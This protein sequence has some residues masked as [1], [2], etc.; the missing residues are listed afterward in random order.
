MQP[1]RTDSVASAPAG[2][3]SPPDAFPLTDMQEAYCVGRFW[4]AGSAARVYVEF[5]V[6]DVDPTA[7]EDAWNAVVAETGMLRAVILPDGRQAVRPRVPRHRLPV[8]DLR[9][10]GPDDRDA[11]LE[12]LRER[13]HGTPLDPYDGPLFVMAVALLPGGRARVH[14]ALD[15]LVV[16]GP[17]VS[18]LLHRWYALYRGGPVPPPPALGFRDYVEAVRARENP[19]R[20]EAALAYWRDKLS[21][22]RMR[23]APRAG[24]GHPG[25]AGTRGVR[26]PAAAGAARRRLTLRLP[27]DR[28]RRVTGHAAALRVT[29]SALLLTLYGSLLHR[30]LPPDGAGPLPLVITTYNRLPVHPDVPRVV[31]PFVSTSV[32]LAP[33][34]TASLAVLSG[35]VR[36][37][38]WA[39]LEHGAVSGVRALRER[40]ARDGD[41]PGAP[42]YVFTSM[43][44]TLGNGLG[45]AGTAHGAGDDVWASAAR[46]EAGRTRTP[47][48]WLECIVH[49]RAGELHVVLDHD[50]E[51]IG[52]DLA[53]RLLSAWSTALGTLA[54]LA[55]DEAAGLPDPAA[56]FEPRPA[57]EAGA[58]EEP[59]DARTRLPLT[60]MQTAYLVGRLTTPGVAGETRVHQEFRLTSPDLRRLGDAWRL[61]VRRHPALRARIGEDGTLSVD[62]AP[63]DPAAPR[64]PHHD[65]THL[66][67]AGAE[68]A[69]TERRGRLAATSLPLDEGPLWRLET[70]ALP[71]G[72]VVLHVLF[73]AL[74]ADARA[75]AT[76]F[77]QLFRLHAGEPPE[78]VLPA[79]PP[80]F[81]PF[82]RARERARQGPA[83][84][85]ARAV[86]DEVL[87]RVPDG[88]GPARRAVAPATAGSEHRRLDVPGWR[89]LRARADEWG[90]APDIVL[91]TVYCD[92]WRR[93]CA[94]GEPFTVVVVSWD[95][96][97]NPPGAGELVTDFTRL[98]WLVVDDSLPAEFGAR[99]RAVDARLRVDLER[100]AVADGLAAARAR[101]RPGAVPP[102]PV[103]FT[104][105]PA[106]QPDGIPGVELRHSQSRTSGVA[107]DHVPMFVGDTLVCQWD[108]RA[109]VLPDGLLDALFADY[110]AVVRDLAG[111]ETRPVPDPAG[112]DTRP[113][114]G[115]AGAP[116]G[117]AVQAALR[118]PARDFRPELTLADRLERA[119]AAHA[120]RLAV[121]FEDEE[122]T[123]REL[124]ARSARLARFLRASGA[125]PGTRVAVRMDRSAALVTALLAVVRAG[126]AYV[127]LDPAHPPARTRLLAEDCEPV[128]VLTDER[129][130]TGLEGST[131]PVVAVDPSGA[132][133][134]HLDDGP[135]ESGATPADPAYMIYTSGTTGRPKGCPN[136]H[137]AVSNRLN[138]AQETF[139]LRPGDRVAQKTPY[140][141]DVSVWEFFWPL[142]AGAAVVVAR[143]EGHR[144][145]AYLARW[146][147]ESGVTVAHFVPSMLALFLAEPEAARA[148]S[149]RLVL[150]S[151][152]ALPAATA[153]AFGRVLPGAE[154]HNL[155]GPTEAAIDVTHWAVPPGWS[156]TDVPLG[157][158]IDNT[159][160]RLLD[161]RLSPVAAGEPGEICV[162]GPAV[163]LGYHRRPEE[164]ALR[165]VPSPFAEDGGG[166]LYRTGDLG[167]VGPD[168]LL[169]YLGRQDDQFKI[170]GLRVEA[171]EVEAALLAVPGIAQARVLPWRGP[172]DEPQLA[173]VCVAGDGGPVPVARLR[174]E[175]ART[176]PAPLLPSRTVFTDALP[177]TPNGKLD[178][179][180]A[181]RLLDAPGRTAAAPAPRDRPGPAAACAPD[182]EAVAQLAAS[183]LDGTAV[184]PDDDLFALG[185]TSFTMIRLA[186]EIERRHGTRVPVDLLVTRPTARGVAEGL[187]AAPAGAGAADG[188]G[189][190]GGPAGPRDAADVR[191]AF[192]PEAK[193]A[194]K[195]ERRSLRRF[196]EDRPRVALDLPADDGPAG[197]CG[198]SVR[199]FDPAPLSFR[200]LS[201]LARSFTQPGPGHGTRRPYPSAGG[202][203]P[204]QVY[205][206]VKP[207]RVTG[208]GPGVY[209]LDPAERALVP[210]TEGA[211][212]DERSQ[213]RYNRPLFTGAAFGLFLV[214]TPRAIEPAYGRA[215]GTRYTA[216]E[217]GHMCQ[218]AMERAS[219][220]GLGLCPIG[221]MD[222]TAVREHF[223]L[224]DGQD[225]VV[226]LWGG[227]LPDSP[228]AP[229]PATATPATSTA[230]LPASGISPPAL[231]ASGVSPSPPPASDVSPTGTA[232]SPCSA[233]SA[234]GEVPPGAV[235]VIG[236]AGLL[237]GADPA[238]SVAGLGRLLAEGGTAIGPPPPG[239]AP[240]PAPR[241]ARGGATVGAYLPDVSAWEPDEWGIPPQEAAAVDPQEHLLLAVVRGCLENAGTR[242]ETLSAAGP[243]GVFTG[244][245]WHDHGRRGGGT[246]PRAVP[247]MTGL[248]HRVSHAFDFHGTSL[249]VDAGCASGLA[250][251]DAALRALRGGQCTTAVAAAVNL[252]L[253]G[254]HLEFLAETGLLAAS[255]GSRPLSGRSDGWI[256]GEGVGAVLLKPLE[257]ALADGDPVHAV[258][259]GGSC[260]H[261]GTTRGYGMPSPRRQE[262]TMRAALDDAGVTADDIGYV[263]SSATGAAVADALELEV[264]GRVLGDRPQ[265]VPVGSVKGVLGHMEAASAF[266][267]L[268]KVLAQFRQDRLLP[269]PLPPDASSPGG[270]GRV[271]VVG[272]VEPWPAR[273][274]V[275]LNSFAGT[276]GYASVVLEAP[277]VR[278]C[279]PVPAG[280]VTLPLSAGSPAALAAYAGRLADHLEREAP[281]L[282]TVAAALRGG[283]RDRRCRAAV[284]VTGDGAVPA[285]R[286]LAERVS[287]QGGG[288]V[289]TGAGVPEDREPDLPSGWL[290]GAD[291]PWP[292]APG[293]VPRAALPPT[294]VDT[295]PVAPR[296][297][298]APAPPDAAS[299]PTPTVPGPAPEP[300]LPADAQDTAAQDAG[301]RETGARDA[302]AQD[303]PA[304]STTAGDL[305]PR[306]V[307]P[308]EPAP[309][310]PLLRLAGIVAR[311]TGLPAARLTEGT[312]LLTLGVDSLRL[313]RIVH[314]ISAAGGRAPS[315]T[316]LYE[317]PV[318]GALA[319]AAFPPAAPRS[320]PQD[321][322]A[323][324]EDEIDA[325]DESVLDA[326]LARHTAALR[327]AEES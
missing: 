263:E 306:D 30:L 98:S 235:A 100:S 283:R 297:Q 254:A 220:L 59:E 316:E 274:R 69:E 152:E 313:V 293:G 282:H 35:A 311:E 156:G 81:G 34:P 136:A 291:A 163:G 116:A 62:P 91:L 104:R 174:A 206:Y 43:L 99:V 146:F 209:Y 143:P 120:D 179:A 111:A 323:L 249:V 318:L 168:G 15:E 82:L 260:R 73:D 224:D 229:E 192:D 5:D 312:D 286:A 159:V 76:L 180:A 135:L 90:V 8:T 242:P 68:R 204:V 71:D 187:A 284:V 233:A 36:D 129:C 314:A 151:G 103:V 7:L 147:R 132:A 171:G 2:T 301:S 267:Q 232:P 305:T 56:L 201:L 239:R 310:D 292:P 181:G 78:R 37:Q 121:R 67:P 24:G 6:A 11:A 28:W 169:R 124:G 199:E 279:G 140:G 304:R 27:A 258:L 190:R 289:V 212:L 70:S 178:R 317:R 252:V 320:V 290:D 33:P 203:Y 87:A 281:P 195:A 325:L 315:L 321:A 270:D 248:A 176:L 294:P 49:E 148:G 296:G 191:I 131:A 17:S 144:S 193:A 86:W 112:A 240:S 142:L 278:A 285:L 25:A 48:V 12:R 3:A 85:A 271:R 164:Q 217:A 47:G 80:P 105:L 299:G 149:L 126:A 327:P 139:R 88:P 42:P 44:G 177:L 65:L 157:R 46:T 322:F 188:A 4:E 210:V 303:A 183:L 309:R 113:A 276:G 259:R 165:F 308:A 40:A 145:P 32:F 251:V 154:L 319:A 54:D 58:A 22:V 250:A 53:D 61:L 39:D 265:P 93:A 231:P 114:P 119:L 150:A 300:V 287:R 55:P 213:V 102:F 173:A 107:V 13:C 109:G 133:Y 57:P 227:A 230:V 261:A 52:P 77:H 272:A 236:F 167:R 200:G 273:R 246:A 128:L 269:T 221:D 84:D 215:L 21:G 137:R 277:P 138:W 184:G 295:A 83:A 280:P 19:A 302:P 20:T 175:L 94:P 38:L 123:Y 106:E 268:A 243:V 207:G 247:T 234:A 23:P 255:A 196:P 288:V 60:A 197:G 79:A 130:R 170:R 198:G 97:E 226:S 275:L 153:H 50:E 45:T 155:Y 63:A 72:S 9:A 257:R 92:V 253:D 202:F 95:R 186:R 244:A 216:V 108:A 208:L 307:P 214:S 189:A 262:E 89:A 266:G 256:L 101:T 228:A 51:A 1:T 18:L 211:V 16:D 31:G 162:G 237:P 298:E 161:A 134:R 182:A 127:P 96:P 26:G 185:A 110:A 10:A 14:L 166:R 194:F 115:P 29:P 245:M 172:G 225:L 219:G 264:L 64:I 222:F 75:V 117:G 223:A 141:F 41:G 326:L 238:D 218:A 205:V 158:P 125:G 160:I 118:G 241:A 324:S 122:L 66:S 74:V